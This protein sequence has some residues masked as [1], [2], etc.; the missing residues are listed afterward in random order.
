MLVD[1]QLWLE[2]S[3]LG[4]APQQI[5]VST[6]FSAPS[7]VSVAIAEVL[8]RGAGRAVLEGKSERDVDAQLVCAR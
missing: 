7:P 6:L 2:E 8:K 4:A 5:V 3:C 1:S